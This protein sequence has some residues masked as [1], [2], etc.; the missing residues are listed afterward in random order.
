MLVLEGESSGIFRAAIR[1]MLLATIMRGIRD[2]S[3]DSQR[4][5]LIHSR[6]RVDRER[7][8]PFAFAT[9][10]GVLKEN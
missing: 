7:K 9:A 2:I 3:S 5:T 8:L 1:S 6:R 10:K 4:Q